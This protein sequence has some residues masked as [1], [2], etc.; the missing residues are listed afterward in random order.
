M[1]QRTYKKNQLTFFKET[2]EIQWRN[3]T[4]L[5]KRGGKT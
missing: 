1:E 2:M 3:D 4:L 5:N